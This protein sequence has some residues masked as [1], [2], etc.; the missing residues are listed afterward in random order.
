MTNTIHTTTTE[1]PGLSGDE[2][3][4]I[5]GGVAPR[6]DLDSIRTKAAAYC[7][8][9]AA[10]YANVE[11]SSLTRGKATRMGNECLSEMGS[12]AASFA[13]GPINEAINSAF[14]R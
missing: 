4:T 2:L 8:E 14:P 6:V 3:S 9:T 10:K 5:T 11:T 13:R 7:P 12:F 1:L